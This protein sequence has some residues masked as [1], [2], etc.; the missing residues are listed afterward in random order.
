MP[1]FAANTLGKGIGGLGAAL[2]GVTNFLPLVGSALGF[3]GSERANRRNIQLAREQMAFQE[4]MSNTAIQRRMADMRKAGIN[5]ILAAK[6]DA[7]TPPGALANVANSGAAA[8]EGG[9]SGITSALAIQRQ[10]QELKNLAA[11]EDLTKA[12]A[13]TSRANRELLLIQSRLTGYNAEIRE[14]AAFFAQSLL[15][16]IP[17]EIRNNP[18][19]LRP[20]VTKKINA[21]LAEHSNSVDNAKRLANDLWNIISGL[22]SSASSIFTTGP[23]I[24][25][26][27]PIGWITNSNRGRRMAREWDRRQRQRNKRLEPNRND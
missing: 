20:W 3:F 2:G 15:A 18:K 12:Q 6:Y 27:G 13:G 24:E 4:R 26:G 14:P 19:A 25:S 21:F 23:D 7:S 11:Q 10:A 5:P 9:R 8:I 22:A 1:T 17:D 16:Q